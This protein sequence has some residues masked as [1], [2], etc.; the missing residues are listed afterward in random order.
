MS[1]ASRWR[2]IPDRSI[3]SDRWPTVRVTIV[4]PA[5]AR[6]GERVRIRLSAENRGTEAVDLH[7]RGRRV[8][9]DVVVELSGGQIVWRR[10]DGEIVEAIVQLR[11]LAPGEVLTLDAQW[12]QRSAA[13]RQVEPG[14]YSVRGLL[15][16]D[17][18]DA[19]ET[20]RVP[21]RVIS[22]EA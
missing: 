3:M 17:A 14:V 21:L 8:A 20:E 4:V 22:A 7:L 9:F 1:V 13:G 2:R 11:T 18:P 15:L 12:D 19:L 5:T 16:T 6:V 10:L